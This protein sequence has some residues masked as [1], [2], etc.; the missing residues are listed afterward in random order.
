VNGN[1]RSCA[2]L[3]TFSSSITISAVMYRL[4]SP[5]MTASLM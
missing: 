4:P 1:R 3:V 5:M 2:H